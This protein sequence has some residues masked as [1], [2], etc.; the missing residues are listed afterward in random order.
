MSHR[1][2]SVGLGAKFK[3][4][5]GKI[6]L[7]LFAGGYGLKY[8]FSFVL[9]LLSTRCEYEMNENLICMIDSPYFNFIGLIVP[10]PF[11]VLCFSDRS[12]FSHLAG[13]AR[14]AGS[15]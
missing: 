3:T 4:C 1:S 15:R 9:R 8:F 10:I 11:S 2:K 7:G 5:R 12:Y 14:S 13:P 6:R